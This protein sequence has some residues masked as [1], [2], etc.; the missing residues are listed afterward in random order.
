LIP[1][2]AHRPTLRT[3]LF[4]EEISPSTTLLDVLSTRSVERPDLSVSTSCASSSRSL[5]VARSK[6]SDVD[7]KVATERLAAVLQPLCKDF[8]TLARGIG[9]GSRCGVEVA[10]ELR[11]ESGVCSARETWLHDISGAEK[12][13]DG[14][15]RSDDDS[16][17]DATT[18]LTQRSAQESPSPSKGR[19]GVVPQIIK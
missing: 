8:S 3:H 1:I 12:V 18:S 17:V 15:L 16:L 7:A 19:D 10:G 5:D 6:V 9:E 11:L 13:S 2:S 4:P 14:Y